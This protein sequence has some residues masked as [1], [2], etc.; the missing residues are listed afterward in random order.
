MC[1]GGR[2]NVGL[3]ACVLAMAVFLIAALVFA[4]LKGKGAMFISGFNTLPERERAQ[5]DT[6]AMSKDM[7]NS[8]LLWALVMAIGCILSYALTPYLAI[9]AYAVWLALFFKDVRSDAS[10]AFGKYRKR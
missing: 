4:Q 7:R 5:Y 9:A 3:T 8:C 2:V 10:T 1:K 6:E